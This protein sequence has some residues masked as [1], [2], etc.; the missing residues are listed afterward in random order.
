[1][2]KNSDCEMHVSVSFLLAQLII[3]SERLY[4]SGL[5][6]NDESRHVRAGC[7]EW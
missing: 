1:M 3:F 5:E 2:W 7:H 4:F 6:V